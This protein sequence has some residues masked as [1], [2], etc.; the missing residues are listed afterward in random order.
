MLDYLTLGPT[1]SSEDC[2][3]LGPKYDPVKARAEC[4]AFKHQLERLFPAGVFKIKSFAHDFGTYMEVCVLY[5]DSWANDT[6]R[7]AYD[8]EANTPETWD[9]QAKAELKAALKESKK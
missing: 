2:E 6:I 3:Q 5:N 8:A 7:A 4:L 9:E 1:P